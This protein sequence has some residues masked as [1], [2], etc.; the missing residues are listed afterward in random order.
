MSKLEQAKEQAANKLREM[1][2]TWSG[3]LP[4][5]EIS[6]DKSVDHDYGSI[7]AHE[8]KDNDSSSDLSDQTVPVYTPGDK[9]RGKMDIVFIEGM[10]EFEFEEI[11][12][13]FV[14]EI[15]C[16][17]IRKVESNFNLRLTFCHTTRKSVDPLKLYTKHV[18]LTVAIF[19]MKQNFVFCS[20]KL[21]LT[22]GPGRLY[23][24]TQ[25]D[26]SFS[27]IEKQHASFYG[28]IVKCRYFV[29]ALIRR[30]GVH[31]ITKNNITSQRDV[32][33]IHPVT[34]QKDFP[35]ASPL[36]MQVGVDNCL[37]IKFHYNNIVLDTNDCLQGYVKIL[38]N[39][40]K[41]T[42]MQIQLLRRE[43][44]T[45]GTVSKP[46][47]SNTEILGRFELMDGAPSDDEYIP[48]R[49]FLNK[50][51]RVG[52]TISN[53]FFSARYYANLGLID[54][55][56]RRYFKTVELVLW[57]KSDNSSQS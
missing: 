36:D 21:C 8:F 4:V 15:E 7:S 57:C 50:F 52:P 47:I 38:S 35:D 54:K 23:Q 20:Q 48:V 55:D 12:V 24:S 32:I 18:A 49:M 28:S 40:L 34:R 16:D 39:T 46:E 41:I 37:H 14:G 22:S 5:I 9:I 19:L 26:F 51:K 42:T 6:F 43:V 11:S 27:R 25:F 33:I 29:R 45:T 56:G 3:P 30:P 31:I 10:K 13:H 53:K 17:Q 2:A 1:T 44:V